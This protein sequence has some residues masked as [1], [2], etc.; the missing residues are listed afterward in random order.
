MMINYKNKIKEFQ[1]AHRKYK[2]VYID[3]VRTE[4]G[5]ESVWGLIDHDTMTVT[6]CKNRRPEDV[7]DT[8]LH[9]IFH[10]VF[11]VIGEGENHELINKVCTLL[12]QA[13]ITAK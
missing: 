3:D 6:L 9:E 13:L 7:F 11:T 2:V 4:D 5:K 8:L 12:A 1:V 10:A